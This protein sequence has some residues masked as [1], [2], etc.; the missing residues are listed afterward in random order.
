MLWI[1]VLALIVLAVAGGLALT[2]LLWFVLIIALIVAIVAALSG[3]R[4]A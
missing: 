3:R 2:K 1:I 4:T